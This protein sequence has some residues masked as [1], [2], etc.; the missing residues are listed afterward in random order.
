MPD[1]SETNPFAWFGLSC[2]QKLPQLAKSSSD[3]Q[4][5]FNNYRKRELKNYLTI[6]KLASKL[7]LFFLAILGPKSW[8]C[9]DHYS[10]RKTPPN[11]QCPSTRLLLDIRHPRL[12]SRAVTCS[13]SLPLVDL[14]PLGFP[15][16]WLQLI[17]ILA[18][19]TIFRLACAPHNES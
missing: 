19:E 11:C 2:T 9:A 7:L 6:M 18:S 3:H 13:K 1:Q 10:T 17:A 16:Y 8:S 4:K 15:V 12:K 5:T 14:Q